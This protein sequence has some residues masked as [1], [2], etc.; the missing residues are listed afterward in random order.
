[1]DD[2]AWLLCLSY[3]LASPPLSKAVCYELVLPEA[4]RRGWA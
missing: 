2:E 1:M 3:Y 4:K